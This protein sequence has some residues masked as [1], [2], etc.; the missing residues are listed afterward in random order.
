MSHEGIVTAG[1][2]QTGRAGGQAAGED[3]QPGS[4][5]DPSELTELRY[6]DLVSARQ[7]SPL[8]PPLVGASSLPLDALD[9]EVLE[10][11]AAELIRRR[12]NQGAHFYGRRGQ[13]Q[14]GLDIVEQE[15]PD[16]NS[17]YQ[18]R[19]YQVLTPDLISSAVTEYAGPAGEGGGKPPRRFAARRYVLL[20]SAPFDNDTALQD[21]LEELQ[22]RYRGDLILEVWGQEKLTA[23]L[24]DCGALVNAV[25]GPE[26]ARAIC[27]FVPAPPGP[28]DPDRLGL[29]ENPVVVL[30]LDALEGDAREREASDPLGSARLYGV[31][32]DAL[33]EASFPV[34]AAAQRRKQ[35]SV[36]A[37]GGDT[38]AA[39]SILWGLALGHF[40]AG[41]AS[42]AGAGDIYRDLEMLRP[43]LTASQAAKA[44]VLKAAQ[45]WYEHGSQLALAVPA[46][47]MLR[48][49]ADADAAL[50]ACVT[51]EQAV[52]DGWFDFDPPCSL[53]HIDGNTGDPVSRLRRCADG[54]HSPAVV[55]RA[56]LACAL[57][58]AAL[59]ADSVPDDVD[60]AFKAI[61]Q[62]AGAGRFR[63][64]GGLVFARAAHAFAMHG[65][66]ARAIDLWRQAILLSSESRLYGDVLACRAALTAAVL[67]QP[68][69]AAAELIPVGPLPND[70]RLLQAAWPP[71]LDALRAAHAGKL[72]AAFGVTR[73]YQWESRLSGHLSDE[74]DAVELFGD[75]LLAARRPASALTA[76]MMAGA[77]AKAATLAGQLPAPAGTGRWAR[78]PARA[79]QAAAAQVIGAQARLY[80]DASAADAVHELLDLAAGFWTARRVEP[81]PE[82]DAVNALTRFGSS[83]PASAVDPILTLLEPR[84]ASEDALTSATAGL[85]IT[86]YQAVPGRRGDLGGVIGQQL[87]LPDCPENLWEAAATLPPQARGPVAPAVSALADAGDRRA[88]LTLARWGQPTAAVQLAA[89]RACAH[90]LREQPAEPRTTWSLT[91]QF[92]DTV[93]LL[94]ALATAGTLTSVDPR[95]L[96]PGAGPDVTA[97]TWLTLIAAPAHPS[98]EPHGHDQAAPAGSLSEPGRQPLPGAADRDA[99]AAAGPAGEP[100][101][102]ALTAAGPPAGLAAAVAGH[103]LAVAE[104]RHTPGFVRSEALWALHSLLG[105]LPSDMN[106]QL[107][108]RFLASAENPAYTGHDIA[109]LASQDP[110]SRG[111]LDTG[112][113]GLPVL[114]LLC[115]ATAAGRATEAGEQALPAGTAQRV[116]THAVPLLHS[117][118]RWTVKHGAIAV[119]VASRS[120][121][122]LNRYGAALIV[123]PSSE[124]RGIA[125]SVAVL[126]QTMQRVLAAD[127]SPDVRMRLAAR[128]GELDQDV[129]AMLRADPH[130][131]VVRAMAAAVG[132]GA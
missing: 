34:H 114:A 1:Q 62:R 44:D 27:G 51:L 59:A 100:D 98:P 112:T 24:R 84:L 36:L 95:D 116:I 54:L 5:A 124:V 68:V 10:R 121:P 92:D 32:A 3:P 113:R 132:R 6:P 7:T 48:A 18:V 20:T 21:R 46:L 127:P 40:T 30:N 104:S 96:L 31:L 131:D 2:V 109:E 52:V 41:A 39:F 11:L 79:R 106:G 71:E 50:L 57:A 43:R 86:L 55:I 85:L 101:P 16:A 23:E 102:Q 117:P 80:S 49:G 108:G 122:S 115:A 42:P 28:A 61:L 45:A 99:G 25:F 120:Q 105:Q 125:A 89:R 93:L 67:E 69:I 75:V 76:W 130:P 73:R 63:E 15:N 119:A 29:V 66:T 33:E 88:L 13:K 87:A 17:V 35:A 129:L 9:P 103:L 128:V 107:A 53:V 126:D 78:S 83:L 82:L 64:A 37:L 22:Q 77:G 26:W 70:A 110:L 4:G 14:Y 123:H 38:T 12:P 90:L 97:G 65:D 72:P 118:D 111:R 58:D 19:R 47:E 60:A 81:T 91:S 74:R 8:P 56:R 94:L